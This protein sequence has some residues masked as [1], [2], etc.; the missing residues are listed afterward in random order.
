MGAARSQ[1]PAAE[2]EKSVS[3]YLG[4]EA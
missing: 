2:V 4:Y 3:L 1:R